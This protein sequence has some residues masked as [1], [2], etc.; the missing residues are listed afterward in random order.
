MLEIGVLV[1]GRGSN[2]EAILGS[3]EK[4]VVKNARVAIVIS[5]DPKAKAL[6]VAR[7]HG[8]KAV[9][10]EAGGDSREAYGVRLA[11]VLAKHGVEPGKGL[12]LLAG[13]MKILPESFVNLYTGRMMNIHPSLLPAFPGIRAQQQA[14]SHGV[15][16]AGCTV[17][18]VVPEVDAGPIILQKAVPVYEGDTEE[19][20]SSRILRQ[21]HR[22]YP[23]AVK[24]FAEGRLHTEGRIVRRER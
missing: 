7:R 2:L 17:H 18:F 8:A 9:A 1:S 4:G 15:K 24:L 21:E 22:L 14:L 16:V 20:L 6:A 3:I 19:S 13:F 5:N 11:E 23:L 10:L 12:V